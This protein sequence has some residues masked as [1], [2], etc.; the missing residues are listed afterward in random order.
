MKQLKGHLFKIITY[1]DK[2]IKE[3]QV[4]TNAKKILESSPSSITLFLIVNITVQ[5]V[6]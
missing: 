1:L 6:R 3:F 5:S 4:C 2:N